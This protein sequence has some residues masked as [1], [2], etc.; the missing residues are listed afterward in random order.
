M[1]KP[2]PIWIAEE[3]LDSYV[4]VLLNAYVPWTC[5]DSSLL[6]HARI[7]DD[8]FKVN[9]SEAHDFIVRH[10]DHTFIT[11]DAIAFHAACL[12]VASNDDERR[13][14][15]DL[16]RRFRLWD[17]A[18]LEM[19]IG[20]ASTGIVKKVEKAKGLEAIVSERRP[21]K[22]LPSEPTELLGCFRDIMQNQ[23]QWA[24]D[25]LPLFHTF[26]DEQNIPE[27][28]STDTYCDILDSARASRYD[29]VPIPEN[30]TIDWPGSLDDVSSFRRRD[31]ALTG[32]SGPFG[33]GIDLQSAIVADHLNHPAKADRPT[34]TEESLHYAESTFQQISTRFREPSL[35]ECFEWTETRDF[36]S[37][38]KRDS[39]GGVCKNPDPW[40][41]RLLSICEN[42]QTFI[43]APLTRP[44]DRKGEL[45]TLAAD[46][47]DDRFLGQPLMDWLKLE[48][49]SS[50]LLCHEKERLFR[51]DS[52][53]SVHSLVPEV[54]YGDEPILQAA[55]GHTFVHLKWNDPL[56]HTLK[57]SVFAAYLLHRRYDPTTGQLYRETPSYSQKLRSSSYA[58][59]DA[60]K[61]AIII[62]GLPPE[63]IFQIRTE[64]SESFRLSESFDAY[65]KRMERCVGKLLSR[66]L[67]LLYWSVLAEEFSPLMTAAELPPSTIP[68]SRNKAGRGEYGTKT[69]KDSP[70]FFRSP[71]IDEL[72]LA[73]VS[74]HF[75]SKDLAA[76]SEIASTALNAR[77]RYTGW[78]LINHL[79]GTKNEYFR[80]RGRA[81]HDS[82]LE[83]RQTSSG[84]KEFDFQKKLVMSNTVSCTCRVGK[85]IYYYELIDFDARQLAEDVKAFVSYAMLSVG[86]DIVLAAQG[87]L[88]VQVPLDEVEE[89][90]PEIEKLYGDALTRILSTAFPVTNAPVSVHGYLVAPEVMCKASPAWPTA[91]T[92]KF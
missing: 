26:R 20:Y 75:D 92:K 2:S 33:I 58:K 42:R 40:S 19:R 46:R 87:H 35:K 78:S 74:A 38:I 59:D 3:S 44:T 8:V 37:I 7:G 79:H 82:F 65:A 30:G 31:L 56:I 50:L 41:K 48:A 71:N 89:R 60:D 83:I 49:A 64:T 72:M 22:N 15:W 6:F 1:P 4:Y 91:D 28:V 70:F 68:M 12:A 18:L 66:F 25:N 16:S 77:N 90:L 84:M 14:V 85:P 67:D 34:L 69:F 10:Q 24:L 55:P 51:Y 29:G 9:A 21:G 27:P 45:S 57:C 13:A 54:L 61:L 63:T 81:E 39:N 86:Y 53:P 36:L 17:L 32:T 11:Y 47:L 80:S 73:T 23:V 62:D 52:F 43:T 88:V 76:E 5:G